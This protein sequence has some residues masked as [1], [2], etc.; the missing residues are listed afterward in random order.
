MSVR[1]EF[2]LQEMCASIAVCG[3]GKDGSLEMS[4]KH[5][6]GCFRWEWAAAEVALSYLHWQPFPEWSAAKQTSEAGEES[7]PFVCCCVEHK[8]RE[9]S[10]GR[11]CLPGQFWWIVGEGSPKADVS[12][13]GGWRTADPTSVSNRLKKVAFVLFCFPPWWADIC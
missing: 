5:D 8:S 2:V 10:L 3:W 4:S 6:P 1:H 9:R 12:V 11:C 7:L 13:C